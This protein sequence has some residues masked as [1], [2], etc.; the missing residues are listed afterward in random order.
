MD[1]M[2]LL[3]SIPLFAQLNEEECQELAR[4]LRPRAY[5]ANQRVFWIG[6]SGTEF[7]I[8][9]EG[10]VVLSFVDERGNEGE[11]AVLGP[12]QFFGEV[13]LLD[14]G[15]RTASARAGTD[16]TLLALE[17]G[18]FLRFLQAKPLAAIHVMTVLGQRTRGM[19]AMLRGIRN[20]NQEVESRVTPLQ[21]LVDRAAQVGASGWFLI[22]NILFM[23][24]W[25]AY[26]TLRQEKP[27]AWHDEPPTFF[28]LGFLVTLEAILLTMFV[29]NSQKRQAERDR[30][31]ADL[32]YQVNLKAHLE[33]M[34]L[35]RKVD[36]LAAVVG[37]GRG[38]VGAIQGGAPI[39][40]VSG[41]SKP[42]HGADLPPVD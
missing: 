27:I 19:L 6:D 1:D 42:D 2:G 8:V 16:L 28:W 21:R 30:V 14:G 38:G 24:T 12:G 15:P 40:P 20:V 10:R 39:P 35:Q 23:A 26:H 3:R 37:E 17:R 31:Q 33:V 25:V 4:L 11:L 32:E 34:E 29:L 5:Q 7:Y 9:Q 13:S 22:C 36:R 41:M 18:A